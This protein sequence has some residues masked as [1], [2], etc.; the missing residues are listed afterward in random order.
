MK[1]KQY[2]AFEQL[3]LS[4]GKIAPKVLLAHEA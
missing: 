2:F 4:E 1:Q 3:L